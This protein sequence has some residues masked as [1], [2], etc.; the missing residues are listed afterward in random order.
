MMQHLDEVTLQAWLDGARSG[1]DPSTLGRIERHLTSCDACAALAD[2]L[3]RSSFRAHGLL[4]VGRDQY[5]PRVSYEDVA[6]RAQHAR[7]SER[8]RLRKIPATWAASIAA[9]LAVG[10][11]SNELYSADGPAG[12]EPVATAPVT[13][14]SPSLVLST[15]TPTAP[16]TAPSTLLADAVAPATDADIITVRG[17]VEDEAGRPVASAQV[18]VTELAMSVLTR[19][20]G[21]YDL[22][23]PAEPD[24]FELTVQRI[25]FRQQ[26]REISAG[27]GDYVDADFRLREEALALDEI[28]VTGESDEPRSNSVSSSR[29]TPFVWRP[30]SSISA[31]GYVGSNLWKLPG[32]DVLTLEVALGDNPNEMHVARVRQRLGDGTTLTFIQGR[33]DGRRARWPIQSAGAVLSTWRG[34]MLITATAP[35]TTDS[36]RVLLTHL[37]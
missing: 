5:A 8:S 17:V 35:V 9:A 15:L 3:A 24:E 12:G 16:V 18:Y 20:D 25:G 32:L 26:A 7:T 33:T 36:L 4:A 13:A 34:E 27:E 19:Q 11:M 29:A 21:R 23:L 14:E 31:E 2:S 37:R 6:K 28:V 22:M 1:L 30:L 10:W